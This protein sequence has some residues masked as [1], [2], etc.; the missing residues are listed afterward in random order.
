MEEKINQKIES[1]ID[2]IVAKPNEEIT[3]D[4]Y[5]ILAAEV[6]DIRFR[7]SQAGNND[8]LAKLMAAF[9]SGNHSDDVK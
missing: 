6:R 5:N 4:D 1:L 8:R 7:K 3:M 9:A 2:Y